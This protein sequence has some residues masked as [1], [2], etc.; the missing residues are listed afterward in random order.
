[1]K[2]KEALKLKNGSYILEKLLNKDKT[3]LFLN[4]ELEVPS[5]FFKIYEKVKRGYPIEYIFNEIEFY[6]KKYY[7]KEGVLIPRDDTEVIVERALKLLDEELKVK[8]K[9]F[10]INDKLN[11]KNEKLEINNEKLK[12]VDCCSGS[13]VIAI[14]IKQYFPDIEVV[15]TDIS[16]KAI[17]V[18]KKNAKLHNVD[19]KFKKCNL[20]DEKGDILISNPPYVENSYPKPNDYEPDIAFYGGVDGLDIVREI[21]LRAKNLEY[22][23]AI[24]EIGYNQK[25]NLSKFLEDKVKEYEFF[26][27]LAR[28]IRGVEIKF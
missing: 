19:I 2:I 1:M 15:A 20:F 6:G 21:I 10:K 3:W 12:I 13:G 9:K 8:S 17:E 18:A 28:N 27:D 7:V 26:K 14:T 25:E 23:Y 5:E 22:K 11:V 16:D 24:I 4:D